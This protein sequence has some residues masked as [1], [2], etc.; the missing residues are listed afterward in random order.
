VLENHSEAGQGKDLVLQIL[1]KSV[2]TVWS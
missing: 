1:P 2:F